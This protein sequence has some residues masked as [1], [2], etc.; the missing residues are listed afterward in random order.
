MIFAIFLSP[1]WSASTE[2]FHKNDIQWIKNSMK[3]Y[4]QLNLALFILGIVMLIFS[5][6]IYRLWLGEGVVQIGFALSFWGFMYFNVYIFGGKYVHFLNGINALRIQFL[7]GIF[8]PVLYIILALFFIKF[9]HLG[10]YSLFLASL[11]ANFNGFILAPLQY[12]KII[13]Q[14]KRGIWIK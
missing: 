1:F 6:T 7:T 3:R 2:A 13:N 10:V 4:G 5:E 8:S 9:L 14:N 12:H 11:L